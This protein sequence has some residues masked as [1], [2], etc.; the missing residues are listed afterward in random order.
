MKFDRGAAALVVALAATTGLAQ[1][2]PDKPT[3]PPKP[4]PPVARAPTPKHVN[5]ITPEAQAAIDKFKSLAFN[6]AEHG[7]ASMKGEI[8]ATG[9]PSRSRATCE[10]SRANGF[11]AT[12]PTDLRTDLARAG[13]VAD[14]IAMPFQ[15][16]FQEAR[17]FAR[18]EFDAELVVKDGASS[19]VV[20]AYSGD[21]KTATVEYAL[22]AAGL[23]VR[24][25]WRSPPGAKAQSM[26][27]VITWTPY[28]GLNRVTALETTLDE[29][30]ARFTTTLEFADAGDV[31]LPIRATTTYGA[32]PATARTITCFLADVVVDGKSVDLPTPWKHA[33]KISADAQAAIDK[34]KSLVHRPADHGLASMKGVIVPIGFESHEHPAFEFAAPAT[35]HV[36]PAPKLEAEKKKLGLAGNVLDY[37]LRTALDASNLFATRECDADV[38]VRDG[39]RILVLD[40]FRDG[41]PSAHSEYELDDAGR[42]VEQTWHASQ[43]DARGDYAMKFAWG[44]AD[45]V[46]LLISY[47]VSLR[48][49]PPA[50]YACEFSYIQVEQAWIPTQYEMTYFGDA[51]ASKK[52]TFHLAD[53]VL[54]EKKLDL[55]TPWKHENFVGE[56]AKAVLDRY[57]SLVYRP[58]EHGM[59]SFSSGFSEDASGAKSPWKFTFTPPL[60]LE[61]V[62]AATGKP[63]SSA[64]IA[65]AI[66]L[67]AAFAGMPIVDREEYDVEVVEKD[68]EKLLSMTEYVDGAKGST[69][70][71]LFDDAGLFA[72]ARP[73]P[74][75]AGTR[76]TLAFRWESTGDLHRVASIEMSASQGANSQRI[77][78]DLKYAT[79][80]GVD[81]L[82]YFQ[83]AVGSGPAERTVAMR[84]T[85]AI[86]NG[87]KIDL[88]APPK[89]ENRISPEAKVLLDRYAALAYRPGERGVSTLAASLVPDWPDAPSA[90]SVEFRAPDVV[91]VRPPSG[92]GSKPAPPR[93]GT[94]PEQFAML[95]ALNGLRPSE[96]GTFDADVVKKDG[97][98]TLVV[99]DLRG[100]MRYMTNEFT[101]DDAGLVA[102]LR[103]KMGADPDKSTS[104]VTFRVQWT[105]LDDRWAIASLVKTA[106]T[107]IKRSDAYSFTYAKAGDAWVPATMKHIAIDGETMTSH[108]Y[109]LTDFVV[110]GKKAAPAEAKDGK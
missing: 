25:D 16:Y 9:F 43:E 2:K 40:A 42:V 75:A 20:T 68:G 80:D 62:S 71:F 69:S 14:V 84:L 38:V 59:Q 107:E 34:F 86:M 104:D 78:Y 19:V 11:V 109:R 47:E 52:F 94:S 36:G 39:K 88:P 21:Q 51:G 27:T 3:P 17:M 53:V 83:L 55:P 29:E 81:V 22:D 64:T 87:K 66:P 18:G 63:N 6:P 106:G 73:A 23:I 37:P 98:A 57:A 26:T 4:A 92:P 28:G 85:D 35:V 89:R 100:G 30:R 105:K 12:L 102:T 46:T 65:F 108:P 93:L 70:E 33:N 45:G 90:L 97:A 74:D 95:T 77:L 96:T 10:Y 99:A 72:E 15:W 32:D 82:A 7:L 31:Q 91:V 48:T 56:K 5:K 50:R 76:M 61:I 67:R 44:D 13:L 41:Q 110:N 49:N 79:I 60:G 24:R 54:N 8:V 101:F 58:G 1:D 103:R